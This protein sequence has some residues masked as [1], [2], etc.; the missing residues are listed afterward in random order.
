MFEEITASFAML[1][2]VLVEFA[3]VLMEVEVLAIV[4]K[5]PLRS[6]VKIVSSLPYVVSLSLPQLCSL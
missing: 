5:M 6:M 2:D 3:L 1:L 4:L